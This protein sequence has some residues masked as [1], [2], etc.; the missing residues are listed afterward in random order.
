[1][2]IIA[3]DEIVKRKFQE[4]QAKIMGIKQITTA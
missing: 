2:N 4:N 3:Q 1:M